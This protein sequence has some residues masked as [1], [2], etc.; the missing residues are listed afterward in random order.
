[1][2]VTFASYEFML[3]Q[4]EPTCEEIVLVDVMVVI[5]LAVAVLVLVHLPVRS[6]ATEERGGERNLDD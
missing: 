4:I 5:V 3:A 6:S 2:L 1:L